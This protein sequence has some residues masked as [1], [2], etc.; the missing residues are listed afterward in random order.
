MGRVHDA[1]ARIQ[2]RGMG[3]SVTAAGFDVGR[4]FLDV[5]VA[6]VNACRRASNTDAGIASLLALL[7][8]HR[9]TRVVLEAIGPYA[10][11]LVQ[12]LV[13]GQ[14][15]VA[16][17]DP[18]RIK[19]WRTAQGGRA[20]TDKVDAKLIASFALVMPDVF[21]PLPDADTL[22][23]RGLSTRRRQLTEMMA[24]EKTRLKQ[25]LDPVV[26]TSH[27]DMIELLKSQRAAIEAEMLACIDKAGLT[28][29]FD[30]LMSAPGVGTAV[31][32]TLVADLPELGELDRRS[33]ASLAGLAPHISQSGLDRGK[34]AISGGRP[35]VR[36]ALYMAA[37]VASR[38]HPPIKDEYKA[39]V[40]AG[41]PP[42]VAL[43]AIARK[44]LLALG[45]HLR[46]GRKW[47]TRPHKNDTQ[48]LTPT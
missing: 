39:M 21:R 48:P 14:F 11:R 33:I 45:A 16:I 5:C 30:I 19:G 6:P 23:L 36:A 20:K 24:M 7:R 43:I 47:G 10:A 42:K 35:C 13:A 32:L 44:H 26:A 9:V 2:E 40:S 27:R 34:A 3:A 37:L 12:A 25:A 15:E 29:R 18:R 8:R 31:A 4:D 22:R 17:V 28:E 1:M 46:E 38:S 41:K